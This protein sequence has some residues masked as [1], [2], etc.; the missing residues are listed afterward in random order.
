MNQPDDRPPLA[1][2]SDYDPDVEAAWE[3][4]IKR[5]LPPEVPG[6]LEELE[7]MFKN[8]QP[9]GPRPG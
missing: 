8:R 6:R 9:P 4:I 1:G 3:E 5:G 2:D 7:A